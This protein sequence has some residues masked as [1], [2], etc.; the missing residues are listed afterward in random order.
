MTDKERLLEILRQ[1]FMPALDVE[2]M[3]GLADYLICNGVAVQQWIPIT[4]RLPDEYVSVLVCIPSEQPLPI[5]KE[6]YLA[7]GVWST[8]M[9][10]YHKSDVT[11]WMPMPEPP[12]EV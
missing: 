12:K 4:E 11:H 7:N 9:W 2:P 3:E 10:I 6:A 5:V 8:K 1:P